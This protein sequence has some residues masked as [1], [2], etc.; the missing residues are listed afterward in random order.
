MAV[1][2]APGDLLTVTRRQTAWKGTSRRARVIFTC[3]LI[4]SGILVS[5]HDVLHL[6]GD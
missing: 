3:P 6:I 5:R 1:T 4:K 2:F